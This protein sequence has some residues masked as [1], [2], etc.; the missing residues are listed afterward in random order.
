MT[1]PNLWA[2]ALPAA[3]TLVE[4][5]PVT[6]KKAELPEPFIPVAFYRKHTEA[7]LR[8]YMHLSMEMG[9]D[10]VGPWQLHV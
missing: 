1:L 6:R 5:A 2:A 4:R 9:K 7:L 8:R 10:A 3:P